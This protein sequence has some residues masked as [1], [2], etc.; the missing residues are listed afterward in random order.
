MFSNVNEVVEQLRLAEQGGYRFV[1][2]WSQSCY[3]DSSRPGDPW[4]YYFEP[5][6][7]KLKKPWWQVSLRKLPAGPIVACATDNIITPRLS[8]GKCD[9]FLLP[10]DRQGASRLIE[11][12][13]SPNATVRDHVTAF[14]Q[15]YFRPQMI[16]LH[17][18]GPGKVDDGVTG[19][20]NIH[21]PAGEVPLEVYFQAVDVKINDLPDAAILACSDSERVIDA[22][23]ARYGDRVVTYAATRSAFG[24]MHLE[25]AENAGLAFEKY[26]LGLDVVVEALLLASTSVLIHGNSNVTNF[27]LCKSPDLKH[28]YIDA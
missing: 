16:G 3:L 1:I 2:D 21:A 28:V 25:H 5:V 26:K 13:I 17:V 19:R 4:T 11:T 12:Y 6:F 8:D 27:V 20:R 9:S 15:Q 24:E 10:R 7:P 18:R 22:I 23:K 14:R